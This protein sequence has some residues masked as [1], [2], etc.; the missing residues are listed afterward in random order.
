MRVKLSCIIF[1][2]TAALLTGCLTDSRVDVSGIEAEVNINRFDKVLFQ[3]GDT[4]KV[5]DFS[6]LRN[7]FGSFVDVFSNNIMSMAGENDTI[8]AGNLSLFIADSSVKSVDADVQKEYSDLQ[9]LEN[10]LVDFFKH[11][12]YYYPQKKIPY[13]VTFVSAFEYG[14][15]TTD[16]I[17]GIGL[18][19]FL[20]KNYHLYSRIGF[21][22]YM[23]AKNS[24]EYIIPGCIK[25]LYQSDYDPQVV[26][27]ELLSQMIYQGKMLYYMQQMAPDLPDTVIT[28]FTGEQLNWCYE[29]EAEIWGF[30][31]EQKLLFNTDPSI[32]AKYVNDGPTTSGFPELSPGKIGSFTG[33]QIVKQAVQEDNDLTLLKIMNNNDALMILESSGYKPKK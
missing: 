31:I 19:M 13:V 23:A 33:W 18:D 5:N 15:I 27:N 20:G 29:N 28:G 10:D 7:K 30:F 16:T 25:A 14:I 17:L 24:K 11:Y 32:Y 6:V 1:L 4:I 21:P 2:L 9:W 22:N 8:T 3:Y 26:K 12:K